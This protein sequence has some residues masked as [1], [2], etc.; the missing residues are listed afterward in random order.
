MKP[1]QI[2]SVEGCE[3]LHKARGFCGRHYAAHYRSGA[4]DVE[5]GFTRSERFWSKVDRSRGPNECWPFLGAKNEQGYGLFS[6]GQRMMR[7]H[8]YSYVIEHGKEPHGVID[9]ICHN[10]TECPGGPQCRHRRCVNPSH[11]EDVTLQENIARGRAGEYPSNRGPRADACHRGH[12]FDA[13]NT[14][15]TPRGHQDCKAC[16]RERSARYRAAR[17]KDQEND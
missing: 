15:I 17:K 8:R 16:A 13:E 7:A 10:G 1:T 2:C 6:S 12:A 5:R 9:H 11:L 4:S 14:Y 3:R